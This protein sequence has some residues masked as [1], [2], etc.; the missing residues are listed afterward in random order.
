MRKFSRRSLLADKLTEPHKDF[1]GDI[2]KN[3]F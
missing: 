3:E 2:R 1:P